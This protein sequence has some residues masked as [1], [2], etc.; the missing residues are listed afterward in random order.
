MTSG[1]FRR[2]VVVALAIMPMGAVQAGTLCGPSALSVSGLTVILAAGASQCD[3]SCMTSYDSCVSTGL[4]A[5][6]VAD[7]E[8]VYEECSAKLEGCRDVCINQGACITDNSGFVFC[9]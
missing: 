4:A 3:T 6:A 9:P 5:Q 7:D 2:F 1:V 8:V